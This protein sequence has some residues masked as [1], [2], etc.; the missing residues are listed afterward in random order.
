MGMKR[1][2]EVKIREWINYSNKALLISGA[3]QVGKTYIVRK[4]LKEAG[5][6]LYEVNFIERP[7]ILSSLKSSSD[8]QEFEDKLSLYLAVEADERKPIVFLD[9]IQEYPEIVT[10]IKFL[11]DGGQ[12]R[13]ILS[14]S[15]LGI[16]I[17]QIRSVP[18][19]YLEEIVMYP[20]SFFEFLFAMEISENAI[21]HIH[22]CFCN[23]VP[24]DDIIH[25]KMMNLFHLYLVIGGMPA[26]VQVFLEHKTLLSAE[27][28]QKNIIQF[29]KS[30]FIK[31]ETLDRKL[32][33]ISI[34]DNIPSQLN[35]QNMRFVFTLLNKEMKFDRYEN[36]FLWL[37]DANV[38]IPVYI[39]NEALAPLVI[40]KDKHTFK[41]FLSDVGLLSSYFP[42]SIRNQIMMGKN[43]SN[44]GALYENFVAEELVA[45]G[46]IPYY[47]KTTAIGEVDFLIEHNGEV[48][49]IEVKSG[50]GVKKHAALNKLLS[51]ENYHLK[52]AI[53]FSE[54]NVSIDKNII[55]LPIYMVGLLQEEQASREKMDLSAY[56]I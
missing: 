51:C 10:K 37:K 12:F 23:K 41:L 14:G 5:F 3:R 35:K 49:P 38:A 48:L 20:M 24:V 30:D 19:G 2:V 8:F 36:S 43:E 27:S 4:V 53:V 21:N 44:N 55:Y 54:S 25:T 39:A 11:V 52:S 40:S 56:K 15:M 1:F 32:R 9:E 47:F 46:I 45:N 33:I 18:I 6:P 31:Y 26:V 17:K 42:S 16:E 28:E 34:Y 22:S 13:Y 29:Y 50:K 7:D